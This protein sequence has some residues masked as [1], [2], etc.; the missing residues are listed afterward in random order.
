[1]S[2]FYDEMA[3]TAEEMISEFGTNAVATHTSATNVVT[4]LAG[5]VARIGIQKKAFEGVSEGDE[6]LICN[7]SFVPTKGDRLAYDG[8]DR[9]VSW[10]EPISPG[11]VVCAGY[12]WT[13]VG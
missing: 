12:I 7:A 13:G 10:Y 9:V 11:G 5:K 2:A 6:R 4:T 8:Q 1:M 3:T